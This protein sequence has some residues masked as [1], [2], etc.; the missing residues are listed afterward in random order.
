ML[1]FEAKGPE[2][3]RMEERCSRLGHSTNNRLRLCSGWGS[4]DPKQAE[5]E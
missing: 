1:D 3:L 2:T 5:E 4:E